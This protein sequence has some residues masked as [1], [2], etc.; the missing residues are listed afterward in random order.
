MWPWLGVVVVAAVVLAVVGYVLGAE[1]R[2]LAVIGT[3]AAVL[4][5]AGPMAVWLVG[6]PR[7][8]DPA[9]V[10]LAGVA[11][12]LAAALKAQ[13]ERAAMERG[14]R[15]PAPVPVRW[16][17][18]D[19]GMTGSAAEA[20]GDSA[21]G[22]RFAPLAGVSRV[23]PGELGQ[24][25]LRDLF[26]VYGGL[27]SGR[28]VLHG[29]AGSGKS[30]AAILLLLDALAHRQG[31]GVGERAGVPVPVLLT[32]HGWDPTS[33]PV[34]QWLAARLALDYPFLTAGP[35]GR[36]TPAR[37]IRDGHVSVFLDGLDEIPEPLRPAAVRALDQ[38]ATFRL[39]V[40]SRSDELAGAVEDGHLRGAA[41]L[42]L[43]PLDPADAADY[44]TRCQTQPMPPAWHR[45]VDHLRSDPDSVVAQALD[46]P[47]TL[48]LVRDTFTASAEI[49]DVLNAD[50]YR[51]RR[52]VEDVLLDRVLPTAYA[53]EP[54]RPAPPCTAAQAQHW[55]GHI[56]YRMNQ[57]TARDLAWWRLARWTPAGL[58]VAVTTL[59]VGLGVGLAY[60][61]AYGLVVGLVVGLAFGLLGGLAFGLVIGLNAG[62]NA[63]LEVTRSGGEPTRINR[64]RW[65]RAVA[66]QRL[67]AG[68]AVGLAYGLGF[69]LAAGLAFGLVAGVVVGLVIGP[70]NGLAAGLAVTRSSGEP[71]RLTRVRWSR[72]VS[73]QGLRF[74]LAAGL[75][76]GLV[77]GL[78]AG[79]MVG[80][81]VGLVATLIAG[82]AV[83]LVAASRHPSTEPGSPTDPASVW[84]QERQSR[85]AYGLTV[86]LAVGLA[87]GLTVGLAYGIAHGLTAGIAYGLTVGLGVA[88]S[89][90]LRAGL[91]SPIWV[92]TFA[93]VQLSR[94]RLGP[95][96]MLRFLEDARARH[97]LR[98]VGP[99]YQFRHARLQDRLAEHF[100]NQNPAYRL[101]RPPTDFRVGFPFR[102]AD[103]KRP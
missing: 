57:D 1:D 23:T 90:G 89:L 31:V 43:W 82:L 28:L 75:A 2:D 60:G 29:P 92:A 97:V 91:E 27:D 3:V 56:A 30:S 77:A 17:W 55:L 18:S 13:W 74:G 58:R 72:A 71:T 44:L 8:Q 78:L 26:A 21:G 4:A 7:R 62:L 53:P 11:D 35:A 5:V 15:Y 70:T 81:P 50:R 88:L 20:A 24:G 10:S 41:A 12:E 84:R 66:R 19:Q 102:S 34:A 16:Q 45:L 95:V 46:S 9:S 69:G 14:L 101:S 103:E 83:G 93:F 98:A 33:Q 76:S 80:L 47:L 54:G 40:L 96:R 100:V 86:G 36:N 68:F 52:D 79:P 64:V 59:A 22:V 87:Y 94:A 39:V 61:F 6:A 38:Q 63:G 25:G 67:V 51:S 85:L 49:D 73:G 65:S 37:L 99:L 42:Q 48:T 32:L